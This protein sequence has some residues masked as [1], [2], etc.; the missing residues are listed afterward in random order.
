MW[1]LSFHDPDGGRHE[2]MRLKPG[3]STDEGVLPPR[4]WRM[5]ELD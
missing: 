2:V 3:V 5:I 1:S 4:E